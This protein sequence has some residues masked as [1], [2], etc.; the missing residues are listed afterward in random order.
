MKENQD[1]FILV[2]IGA[3]YK[4]LFDNGI[5]PDIVTTVDPKFHILNK[6]HFN[7][8]DVVLLK[9]TI[10]LASINTPTKILDRFNQEK[11]FLYEVVDNF[12]NNSNA[13][14][15]IS[16]G[17]ITLSLL[18][19]MNVKEIY[20]LGTDLAFDEK[21]GLS[22]FEGYVNKREDFESEKS[23]VDE[24]LETGRT[25]RKEFILVKGNKKEQVVTNRMFALSINQ[26]VRIIS[27]FKKSYQNIYNLCED[28]AYIEGTIL[29]NMEDIQDYKNIENK[30]FLFNNLEKISEFK[31]LDF[32]NI[33][34]LF[35]DN[36]EE[37]L[38]NFILYHYERMFF[39]N[40]KEIDN[41]K[42]K[43]KP[44]FK[45]LG[46]LQVTGYWETLSSKKRSKEKQKYNKTPKKFDLKKEIR[47]NIIETFSMKKKGDFPL[48]TSIKKEEDFPPKK[49]NLQNTQNSLNSSNIYGK[50]YSSDYIDV[51]NLPKY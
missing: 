9:D 2:A 17:E 27:Y 29:K 1:K 34:S 47:N 45:W 31:I 23:K 15:G 24:V 39:F 8:K 6:T 28:G 3:T 13:Y 19:D 51:G 41:Q 26:Y 46:R 12:K 50:L 30:D 16:V 49:I 35:Q 38:Q 10:V 32:S 21:T 40:L 48:K 44:Q 33:E 20:L 37:I 4:K 22:H 36:T 42:L 11:L 25:S 14:N 18:L 5:T 43:T 7:E